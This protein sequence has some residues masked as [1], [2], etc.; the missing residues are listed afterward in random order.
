MIAGLIAGARATHALLLIDSCQIDRPAPGALNATTGAYSP[1]YTLVYSG[2]CR[3]KGPSA[4]SAGVDS[5]VVAEAG[6][7]RARHTLVLPHGSAGAVSCGDRVQMTAG[8]LTG[9][10]Y[11]VVGV[12]DSSTMSAGSVSIEWVG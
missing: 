6:Q 11:T 1:T 2:V 5:P 9:T 10:T 4:G 3:V 12:S 8:T 7:Q